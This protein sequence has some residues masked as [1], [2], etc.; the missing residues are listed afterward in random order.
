MQVTLVD[1]EL[2]PGG[3]CLYRGCIPS[4]ALLHV[5]K[6][7][8]RGES[9]RRRGASRYSEP[10]IDLDKL[11]AFKDERR[12]EADRRTRPG[13]EAAQ[14]HLHPGPRVVRRCEDAQHGAR[15][16]GQGRTRSRP[17]TFEHAIIATGSRPATVPGLSIDSP[18]VMDSTAALDLPDIPEVAARRRRRL[19]RPRARLGLRRAR[20]QGHRRRDDRRP[21]ARRRSRSRHLP[22]PAAR[23]RR[24]TRF[25][26]RRTSSR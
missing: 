21:A 16:A 24:C 15:R 13:V 12:P 14:G 17:S 5:A 11:R 22:R 18:R 10:K 9:T 23:D 6:V 20:H 19:H 3:V 1:T 4:K 25:C 7:I 8:V 26:S 2:N